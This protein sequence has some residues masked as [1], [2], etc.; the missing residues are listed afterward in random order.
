MRTLQHGKFE[1]NG[2][3]LNIMKDDVLIGD[4]DF[5]PTLPHCITLIKQ[6]ICL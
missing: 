3:N 4:I 6:Q 5:P 2:N 1:E